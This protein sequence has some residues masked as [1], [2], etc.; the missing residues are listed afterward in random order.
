M[1]RAILMLEN[2]RRGS[3]F[4]QELFAN[5][6]ELFPMPT[7]LMECEKQIE[8]YCETFVKQ[9]IPQDVYSMWDCG[10][11]TAYTDT[12]HHRKFWNEIENDVA[13]QYFFEVLCNLIGVATEEDEDKL[14]MLELYDFNDVSLYFDSEEDANAFINRYGIDTCVG[15]ERSHCLDAFSERWS[16]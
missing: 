2:L 1:K 15:F 6:R 7:S 14:F 11:Y 4:N 8:T 3:S 12:L 16:I 9:Y 13:T 5:F 10:D